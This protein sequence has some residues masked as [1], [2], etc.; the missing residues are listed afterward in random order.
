MKFNLYLPVGDKLFLLDD[1][2]AMNWLLGLDMILLG[3]F[4]SFLLGEWW[5]LEFCYGLF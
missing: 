4:S 5:C 3:G 2:E 1:T